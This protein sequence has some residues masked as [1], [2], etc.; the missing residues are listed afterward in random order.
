MAT[1]A[2]SA[3][4]P[5]PGPD[6]RQWA[7]LYADVSVGGALQPEPAAPQPSSCAWGWL[8]AE[9]QLN[10]LARLGSWRV[11]DNTLI[12]VPRAEDTIS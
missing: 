9:L 7:A 8:P 3:P 12:L 10:V 11:E 1:L 5:L 6:A 2:L 4:P